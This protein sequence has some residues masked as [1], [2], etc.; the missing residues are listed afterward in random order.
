[1]FALGRQPQPRD[2]VYP[3]KAPSSVQYRRRSISN[4]TSSTLVTTTS[5]LPRRAPLV[6]IDPQATQTT[7]TIVPDD[8]MA[9]PAPSPA[10]LGYDP[11]QLDRTADLA[12]LTI[13]KPIVATR[14][15]DDAPGTALQAPRRSSITLHS[16]ITGLS[17]RPILLS[18][19]RQ[20]SRRA[21]HPSPSDSSTRRP[22]LPTIHLHQPGAPTVSSTFA[23]ASGYP[24]ELNATSASEDLY[25]NLSTFTFGAARTGTSPRRADLLEMISPLASTSS[26]SSADRTPRPSVSGPSSGSYAY[27]TRSPKL[28]GRDRDEDGSRADD[29]DDEEA[30][31]Q[32][33]AKM[34]AIDDGRRRPSLPINIQPPSRS[35][36]GSPDT[37]TAPA[38]NGRPHSC[39]S[40]TYA[41]DRDSM[42]VDIESDSYAA[43]AAADG[44]GDDV[45]T[46]V[47]FDFHHNTN[48]TASS[49]QDLSD[50]ASVD[51]FGG[52]SRELSSRMRSNERMRITHSNEVSPIDPLQRTYQSDRPDSV[53]DPYLSSVVLERR[54]SLPWDI[55]GA[56]GMGSPG[57]AGRDREDSAATLT[58]RRFS[59]SLDDELGG[60]ALNPSGQPASEPLSRAD[61]RSL[62]AQAQAHEQQD[63]EMVDVDV[64]ADA[65][66]APSALDG[67]DVGYILSDSG[68][69][70]R[71]IS[72]GAP[73]F[74]QPG[75]GPRL[76][77]G[78]ADLGWDAAFTSGRR[79][80]TQ[81]VDKFTLFVERGD[82]H[83]FRR[84]AEWSFKRET[85]GPNNVVAPSTRA[86]LPGTVEIWRQAHVGRYKVDRLVLQPDHPGKAPQ[87]RVNVRHFSDPF[88]KGNTRG[89][90]TAVIHKHSRAVAFS[91]FRRHGL[92]DKKRGAPQFVNTSGSILLATMRVQEQYTNTKTTSQLNA[93]G[94]LGDGEGTRARSDNPHVYP[95]HRSSESPSRDRRE[96][97]RGKEKPRKEKEKERQ[98]DPGSRKFQPLGS[99]STSDT[100]TS[101]QTASVGSVS[102]RATTDEELLQKGKLSPH[103]V[104]VSPTIAEQPYVMSHASSSSVSATTVTARESND[105][106][107]SSSSSIGGPLSPTSVNVEGSPIVVQPPARY[108]SLR[109]YETAMDDDEQTPPRTS[110]A[111]AF[112]T[113]DPSK[114][115][116]IRGRGDQR[117]EPDSAHGISI[118]ERWRRKLLGRDSAKAGARLPS[119]VAAAALE[120]YYTPPWMTMA[121]RS[122]QEE[123]ERVIQNLNESF[124]D[125]G[126]LPSFRNKANARGKNGRPRKDTERVN[127]FANVPSDSLHMLLPLWPGE[128]DLASTVVGEEPAQYDVPLEERQYLLVYYVPFEEKHSGK[129]ELQKKRSRPDPL[130]TPATNP[131]KGTKT[132]TLLHFRVCARLVSYYDL[133]NTG[134]R[135][136]INGLS[137]T[138]PMEEALQLLPPSEIRALGLDDIV[139][140]VCQG[141]HNGMEFIPEGLARLG[142]A[143]PAPDTPQTSI[144][145]SDTDA[146]VETEWVLTPIGRA[147]VEMAWLGCLA[148]TSFGPETVSNPTRSR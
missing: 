143:Q 27:R 128:T 119:G 41:N 38:L 77:L 70:R 137:V 33:R 6:P 89:G 67:F 120:G 23:T 111:E 7:V 13:G 5:V 55:P 75:I 100:G 102:S 63:T 147:A 15:A 72:S 36:S 129:K 45:D 125:V 8:P 93:H 42:Q 87:Q 60:G 74:V 11:A 148:M 54:G 16:Q 115:D 107:A 138:G 80:S 44:D 47:E 130:A 28:Q 51:T 133:R 31:R 48:I 109:I 30:V 97:E 10:L 37:S 2:D 114:L 146:E 46:D 32:T 17:P 124:K 39:R 86:L 106:W 18:P 56:S 122:K 101:S 94:F 20:T 3:G 53:T 96:K 90:P 66:A 104:P 29:E 21:I 69:F 117:L 144:P 12:R 81:T 88:S 141:R 126:L 25:S 127:I 68:D 84:R 49:S 76:S 4:I 113:L 34:R 99:N 135:L 58:G 59:R 103:S 64:D 121:P 26:L 57:S 140:G 110:H 132:I 62:E 108:E 14:S 35:S 61:W 105:K 9:A 50:T 85:D 142:L 134:V 73:S 82:E 79:P 139:I 43:A 112:A 116:Y 131:G 91:I 145:L 1:M 40:S 92:F 78:G 123:R 83:Y 65:G 118:T 24:P 95:P 98:K 19:Q 52:R 136:P 71:S 22:S